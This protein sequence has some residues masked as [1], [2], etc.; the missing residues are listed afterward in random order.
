MEAWS[1]L[2]KK[3]HSH[4]TRL[5]E[6][7]NSSNWEYFEISCALALCFL[8]RKMVRSTVLK[9]EM[10]DKFRQIDENEALVC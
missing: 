7:R 1:N 4:T 9:T 2:F 10:L 6:I 3:C 5:Q 8:S